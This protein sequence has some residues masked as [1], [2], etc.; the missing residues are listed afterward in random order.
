[1]QGGGNGRTLAHGARPRLG[2]AVRAL[3]G[4]EAQQVGVDGGVLVVQS[5]G[6][7]KAAGISAGDVIIAVNGIEV[8]NVEELQSMIAR[9]K[10][11]VSIVVA[12]DG[13]QMT[14]KV[15]LSPRA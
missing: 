5:G 14:A 3:T 12:R 2:V 11:N 1:V 4:E 8:Q 7:A 9:A 15:E 13:E 6:P 10:G